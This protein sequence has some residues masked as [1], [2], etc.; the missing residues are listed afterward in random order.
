VAVAELELAGGDGEWRVVVRSGRGATEHQVSVPAGMAARLG[1][2]ERRLVE[3]S[4][5]FL[6]AR[7]PASAILSRFSLEV[8]GRYFPEYERELPGLL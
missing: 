4:F 5:E 8:I 7:E 3:A 6:L 2:D 1:A